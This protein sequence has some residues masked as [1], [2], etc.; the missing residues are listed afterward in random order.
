MIKLKIKQHED[1]TRKL[2]LIFVCRGLHFIAPAKLRKGII[3]GLQPSVTK[4]SWCMPP[5][6]DVD[7]SVNSDFL[8]K[9]SVHL[10]QL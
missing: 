3:S 4:T 7:F 10:K 9:H 1:D 5:P 2:E 6:L 8:S